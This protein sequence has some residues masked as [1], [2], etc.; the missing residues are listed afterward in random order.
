MEPEKEKWIRE[1]MGSLDNAQRA[2]PNP[3]LFTRIEQRLQSAR[4]AAY[5]STRMVWLAA[6]SFVLL[7]FLNVQLIRRQNASSPDD[8][9]LNPVVSDMQLYPA[10][11]QLYD[12]WSEPNY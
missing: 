8:K 11:N 9:S 6:T 1:V 12:A 4:P 3:F 5:V 7:L 10:G 2:E